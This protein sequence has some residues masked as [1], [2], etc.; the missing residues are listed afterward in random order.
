MDKYY[1]VENKNIGAIGKLMMVESV[2]F[3]GTKSECL[4]Y[5]E[6]K[7]REY[8][9]RTVIDCFTISEKEYKKLEEI[10]E[11]WDSLS[12]EKKKEVIVVNGKKYNKA[13]YEH[14]KRKEE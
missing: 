10:K 5:E 4:Q 13:L 9:D 11:F 12:P 14:S 6:V 3:T 1:V 7:R 8:I 2:I